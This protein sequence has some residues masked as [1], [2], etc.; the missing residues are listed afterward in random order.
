MSISWVFFWS[1]APLQYK[2]FVL[3]G[4]VMFASGGG[5]GSG[6]SRFQAGSRRLSNESMVTK[7]WFQ[8]GR[9]GN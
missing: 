9:G 2:L 4:L 3:D 1:R 6:C 5:G 7:A 8:V